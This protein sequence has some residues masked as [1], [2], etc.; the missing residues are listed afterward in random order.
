ML[1]QVSNTNM[2]H[3]SYEE[4]PAVPQPAFMFSPEGRVR[5]QY[6][7]TLPAYAE[8]DPDKIESPP[9]P[10]VHTGEEVQAEAVSW[11]ESDDTSPLINSSSS[12]T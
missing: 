12:P 4:Q 2:N 5:S 11:R 10:Y 7:M 9:P 6:P 1:T 8:E 3:N